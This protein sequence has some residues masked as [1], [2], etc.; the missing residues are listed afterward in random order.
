MWHCTWIVFFSAF[1]VY[2]PLYTFLYMSSFFLIF[3]L[4]FI[5]FLFISCLTLRQR[6]YKNRSFYS[7]LSSQQP[8][9]NLMYWWMPT[10]RCVFSQYLPWCSTLADT[11]V[12]VGHTEVCVPQFPPLGSMRAWHVL[13]R[14]KWQTLD[15]ISFSY[16]FLLFENFVHACNVFFN[17]I[18]LQFPP[19]QWFSYTPYHISLPISCILFLNSLSPLSDACICLGLEPS[20]RV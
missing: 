15:G 8:S 13:R 16:H 12:F 18:H 10:E 4:H 2:T 6:F 7:F 3:L 11:G 20:S 14:L 9:Q 1:P 19:L 17:E 5:S